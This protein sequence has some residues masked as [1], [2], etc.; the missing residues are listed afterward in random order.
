MVGNRSLLQQVLMNLILNAC[1]AMPDGGEVM[2]KLTCEGGEVRA[3]VSD[4]GCGIPAANLNRVFDPFF[5]TQPIG[6]GT[7]LGL[8]ISHAIIQQHRG[9][10]ELSSVE[11]EGSTF[12]VHLPLAQPEA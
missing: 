2:V 1:Q 4:A 11:G 6:K 5:T 3:Q 9:S 10:I 12:T 7:G 8:S